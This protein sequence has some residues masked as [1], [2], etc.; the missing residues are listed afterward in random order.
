MPDKPR[1]DYYQEV[2]IRSMDDAKVH[3][4]GRT[5]VVLGRTAT[6]D[7]DSWYYTVDVNGAEQSWCFFESELESTGRRFRRE[8]FYDGTSKRVQVDKH[9]RG[10]IVHSDRD[11]KGGSA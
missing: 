7:E 11:S 5:G 10:R 1:F 9:G 6:A 8:D 2:Q 3:L 4:N